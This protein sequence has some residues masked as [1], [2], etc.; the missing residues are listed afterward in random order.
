MWAA[1]L[2]AG[3]GKSFTA[4]GLRT[5]DGADL[6]A[7]NVVVAGLYTL[8]HVL[9]AVIDPGHQAEGQAIAG[10]VDGVDHIV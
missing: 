5:D 1:R 6:V 10:G 7:V 8:G 2:G 4:K 9:D 3:A